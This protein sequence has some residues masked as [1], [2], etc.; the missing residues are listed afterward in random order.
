MMVTR[1]KTS[2]QGFTTSLLKN[3]HV[4]HLKTSFFK[5]NSFSSIDCLMTILTRKKER[6]NNKERVMRGMMNWIYCCI[7]K[8]GQE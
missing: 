3:S 2:G 7:L 1:R 8:Q 4:V 6:L 5:E